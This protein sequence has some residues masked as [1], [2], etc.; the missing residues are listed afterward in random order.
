MAKPRRYPLPWMVAR[1]LQKLQMALVALN[2]WLMQKLMEM[3][4]R[5]PKWMKRMARWRTL[6]MISGVTILKRARA[7]GRRAAHAARP[8]ISWQKEAA[9]AGNCPCLPQLSIIGSLLPT[10]ILYWPQLLRQLRAWRQ[11][12]SRVGLWDSTIG[13][14]YGGKS[15]D[16]L[17]DM[18]AIIYPQ[19]SACLCRAP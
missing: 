12:S 10:Y 15:W 1:M 5:L 19:L 2:Q 9:L 18:R 4:T 14:Y 7:C 11:S 16:Y 17:A 8:C 13:P 6:L 3:Q